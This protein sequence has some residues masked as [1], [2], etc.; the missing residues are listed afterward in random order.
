MKT[1]LLLLLFLANFS[2]Y[3]QTNLVPNGGLNLWAGNTL[4]NWTATNGISFSTANYEGRFSAQLSYINSSPK[5]TAQVPLQAGVT[6]TIKLKYQYLDSNYSGNH[7]ISLNISKNGSATTLSSSTLAKNNSWNEIEATFTPDANL[8]YDLSIATFSFDNAA[9]KVLIDH[10]QVYVAG[11]EKYTQIPDINFE[12]KLIAL[13]IDSG[14]PDGKVQTSNIAT[15]TS[16]DV[17]SSNITNLTGIEDFVSLTQLYVMGNKLT[18]LDASK[19]I[20]LTTLRCDSN[21]TITSLN[22]SKN[23][24]LVN[25]YCPNNKISSLDLSNLP[26]LIELYCSGNQ[27]SSLDLSANKKIIN[28]YVNS[29][30]LTALDLSKNTALTTIQC[31]ENARLETLNLQNGKNTLLQ[32]INL[33][34]TPSLYCILVD[35]PAYSTNN[36]NTFKDKN[37]NFSITCQTPEY[38]LIPDPEFEKGLIA[39]SVD[40]IIDGKVM[41]SK[42]LNAERLNINIAAVTDLT[43]I[44]YFTNLKSLELTN[45]A[46]SKIT[47]IDLS[48]F[49]QLS[50]FSCWSNNFSE[51]DVSKNLNLKE[52]TLTNNKLTKIDVTSNLALE[53]LLISTNKITELNVTKNTALKTLSCD[54]N[55]LAIIDISQ[56]IAL[57]SLEC[58]NTEIKTLDVTN[59]PSL[60]YLDIESNDIKLLDLSKNLQLL[61][62]NCDQNAL[63]SLDVS[64]NTLLTKVTCGYN[65]DLS[66]LNLKNGNN[67][68]FI[69]N[70][71]NYRGFIYAKLSCIEVDDVEYS[72]TN[73]SKL[74]DAAAT[75][76][77]SCD[78]VLS[79]TL[80]PD[81]NFE[82][83]LILQGIDKDGKNGKVLTSSILNLASLNV[84]NSNIKDLTGIEDFVSLTSLDCSKNSLTALNVNDNTFLTQLKCNNNNIPA[85]DVSRNTK[86]THLSASFNKI[87]NLDLSKNKNLKEVDCA[88]NNLHN[89]NVKNGNNANM[90]RMIFG[91]FTQNP[92][93]ICIEV[94]DAAFAD[95]NWI[96]KD[97]TANYSIQACPLNEQQ[98]L[99]PDPNFERILIAQGIDKDGENGKVRTLSISKLTNLVLNDSSNKISDLTGIQ[100][101]TGLKT[102]NAGNNKIET[103]DLSQNTE[104]FV[105][106]L[107][108]NKLANIDLS[109]NTLIWSLSISSNQLT[110]LDVSK[111][112]QLD[113]LNVENNQLTTLDI[114]KNVKLTDLLLG[115]NKFKDIDL[116]QNTKLSYFSV[117]KNSLT[118]LDLSNNLV[119]TRLVCYEN[120]IKTLDL[121]KNTKL[122]SVNVSSNKLYKLNLK[123]GANS[124]ITNINNSNFKKNP[125]LTCIQV[126]D[127]VFSNASWS[128]IIDANTSFSSE[129]CPNEEPY[130]LI[131]DVNFENKL[132]ALGID[133]DGVNGKVATFSIDTVT[134]LSVSKSAITDLTGLQNFAAL[135]SLE[136]ADNK[137]T[138]IN[139]DNNLLLTNLNVSKNQLTAVNVSKNNKLLTLNCSSNTLTVLNISNNMSLSNLNCSN[140]A[141]TALDVSNHLQLSNLNCSTNALTVLNVSKNTK[142]TVLSASINKLENLDI[143][144]NSLL[145]EIDCAGNN[146]YNLNLK[147]GNNVNMERVIFGNFTQNP[148]LLCIQVDDAAFS[149][150]KWIAKDAKAT[151]SSQPCETN[152]QYTL[153]PDVNFEKRLISL[154]IDSGAV[155]GKVITSKISNVTYLYIP[156]STE[157]I[158]DLT[159]IA[160]FIALER[161][162]CF[163]Q[164]LTNIDLS[165]N[166]KLKLVDVSGNNLST[167]DLSANTAV[168]EVV[169]YSNKFTALDFSNNTALKNINASSN[170]LTTI[171]VSKNTLLSTL[172]L[173]TNKIANIDLSNNTALTDL[174]INN[175]KLAAIDLSKNLSLKT[176]NINSN[177][178]LTG[179]NISKNTMLTYL[180]ASGCYLK[181]LDVSNNKALITLEASGSMLEAL[182]I[183]KNPALTSL[184]VN[185]NQLTSLNL[186][187]G[188]NTSLVLNNLLFTSN[189][190]LYCIL[191]DDVNYANTNWL[192]KKDGIATYNTECTGEMTLPVNNFTVETKSESCLGENN[193]EISIVGK[194]AFAYQASINDKTYT[195]T[196]NSLKV[197]SLVPGVYKIKIT[198]PEMIFEQNFTVTIAKGA[199]ITGKSSVTSK[200]VDVE[201]TAGTAPFTVFVDGAEQ[202]QTNDATFSVDVNKAALVEVATAKACEGIFSKKVAVSDF[203][204]QILSAYPNPTSGSFEIEIPAA[205]NEVKIELY[206]FSGQLV[207]TKTYTIESGK[208]QLN[209]E[210]Q[211]SGIYAAKIYLENPEYI[212]IIKK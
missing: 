196:N 120:Q 66:Y 212:K 3:A 204:S 78:V 152:Y 10:V 144:K 5:I 127:A 165:A 111:N 138:T 29:N 154:G 170:Q 164:A 49:T 136:A 184:R 149:N 155:D 80:I 82:D 52:L 197:A 110:N 7:P 105:L 85:L 37:V 207:S 58:K 20:E 54:Q 108:N 151:Y 16:L 139:V 43:G 182:D 19:N 140:N 188:K 146:L 131:P 92:K 168:E 210:N 187:N 84:S 177:S 67:K 61:N 4:Q 57:Q 90:Q 208:A 163:G 38:I 125:Y 42:A 21:Y 55:P 89:L 62:L 119:L 201:I 156:A 13:G 86:L 113:F 23:S 60:Q 68:N 124:L 41:K 211:P 106:N 115:N 9:F 133:K 12:N 74:K 27:L 192:S 83:A 98:T 28:L 142:L 178:P 91:N 176:L 77:S 30:L 71:S 102:L 88:S 94:D 147:N 173:Y 128:A 65:Y 93:L 181:T 203:E 22:V 199:T 205:K 81:S 160:D 48:P 161:F 14:L 63:K 157:K 129:A 104:L 26:E 15:I 103:I 191:V 206:N 190:K 69:T 200:T 114:S 17:S 64:K 72:N 172:I 51:I 56:N 143:S 24:K 34:Y 40:G 33:N 162:Y 112:T 180:D 193:G 8:S 132:I 31:H 158:T 47:K 116:S 73:W 130:T 97:A 107:D 25:L 87:I 167:L 96:A 99:I 1:K 53:K 70:T 59:N 32:K 174:T 185:S 195:F 100:D 175:N 141:I 171:N 189:P 186:Q 35:D 109:N 135:T 198:I 194:Q 202:F 126:D 121:S 179:L 6:Y 117:Y 75:Y 148:N 183:T 159:G 50:T 209:L 18:T 39:S 44:E 137:L 118:S 145:K 166:K 36:W 134:S 122:S 79:Y 46:N 2:I 153:I 101:F 45:G 150:E 123:N 76:S 11:T 95:A 169:C